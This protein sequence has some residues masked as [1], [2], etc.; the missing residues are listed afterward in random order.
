MSIL[1]LEYF[2]VLFSPRDLV[3]FMMMLE[4]RSGRGVDWECGDPALDGG[5]EEV[6]T[7][8]ALK[9]ARQADVKDAKREDAKNL[10]TCKERK[11]IKHPEEEG[12]DTPNKE[13]IC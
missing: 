10:V 4:K 9:Q 13:G 8:G 6:N 12:K 11:E 1:S 2:F 5:E 7:T 3:E